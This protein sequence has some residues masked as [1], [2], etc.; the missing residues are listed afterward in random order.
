VAEFAP[1]HPGGAAGKTDAR[2]SILHTPAGLQLAIEIAVAVAAA[3]QSIGR[4]MGAL[5]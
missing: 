3:R 2:T 1:E 4:L 5:K